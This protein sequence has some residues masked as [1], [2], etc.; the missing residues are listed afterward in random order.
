VMLCAR[1]GKPMSTWM[2]AGDEAFCT[3]CYEI[4]RDCNRAIKCIERWAMNV[5]APGVIARL[6]EVALG[7]DRY[8]YE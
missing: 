5:H 3:A 1:C 2:R 8:S 6:Q 7:N 4:W